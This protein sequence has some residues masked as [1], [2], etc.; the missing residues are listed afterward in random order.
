MSDYSESTEKRLAAEEKNSAG[1]KSINRKESEPQFQNQANTWR[2]ILR[3]PV[4]VAALGYMVDMYD[5]FLFNIVR[6]PSLKDLG[7]TK[8]EIFSGGLTILNAQMVGMLLGGLLWGILGDKKGRLS[9]LFGSIILYSVANLANAFVQSYGQYFILRF[10]AGVGLAGELGAGVT[11]VAE[12][13]PRQLRGYG[14]TIVATVGLFGAVLAYFVSDIFSWRASFIAGGILGILLLLTR[15]RVL[16]SELFS[17]LRQKRVSKGNF[18]FLFSNARHFIKYLCSILIGTPIWFVTGVL[19]FFSPEFGQANGITVP[20]IAGKAVM[21]TLTSQ[22]LGNIVSGY[23]SQRLQSRKKGML[24]FLWGSYLFMLV[25]LLARTH[26]AFVFYL[27]CT[28]LGFFNGYWTLFITIAAELF[29]TN[30][31]STVATTVPNFVRASVIPVSAFFLFFKGYVGLTNAG[32]ITATVV[33]LISLGALSR[34][35]ETFSKD[36]N[37][38]EK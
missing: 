25:Y 14:T 2:Q 16:E 30:I 1:Q 20:V 26:S 35:E 29:G 22:V 3:I 18:L 10:I 17:S 28:L 11:L 21:L 4:I 13:L 37:Y 9:V 27:L 8:E 24:Y 5:L 32:I 6:V 31:R 36:L 15:I 34:L 19:I 33:I 23:L 12:I 7:L 38:E